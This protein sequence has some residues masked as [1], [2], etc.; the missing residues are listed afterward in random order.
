MKFLSLFSIIIL[1]SVGVSPLLAQT[2]KKPLSFN[3]VRL[4]RSHSTTLS[5]DGQW[6][7]NHY[8]LNDKPKTKKDTSLQQL[9]DQ[10]S[11]D[12]YTDNN[13]TNVLY[14]HHVDDGLK[15]EVPDGN[16]PLF[17]HDSKWIA[18]KVEKTDNDKNDKEKG[19]SYVEL[20][21]LET[22][23]TTKFETNA[24]YSFPEEQDYF[25]SAGKNDLLVFD[26][27]N[28]TE[29]FIGNV[30]EYVADKNSDYVAYTINTE[31]KRGNGIYLYHP[32]D[33]TT[34]TITTGNC[35]FSNLAWNSSA[36]ALASYKYSKEEAGQDSVNIIV[37]DGLNGSNPS[38]TEYAANEI[39]GL[40][41]NRSIAANPG[42]KQN[43]IVWSK[44]GGRL[45]IKLKPIKSD[46]EADKAEDD[47]TVQV[48]HWKDKKLLSER[49]KD[50]EYDM[51]KTYRA[52][53]FR[54]SKKIVPLTSEEL[55]NYIY[56]EG[57]DDWAIGTDNREYLS[58]WDI[59]QHDLYRLNLKTGEKELIETGYR[60][61]YGDQIQVSPD[62]TKAF[63]W[64][65]KDY[66][67]YDFASNT[68]RNITENLPVSF[69]DA[70]YDQWGW[71]KS[72]GFVGWMKDRK[73][74]MANHKYDLWIIPIDGSAKAENLTAATRGSEPIRFRWEDRKS[75]NES[76][77]E[78][79]YLDLS[80]PQFLT[81]FHTKTK[82]SGLYRLANKAV[83]KVAFEPQYYFTGWY[84][85]QVYQ[86]K[87]SDAILFR[88]GDVQHSFETYLSDQDF[89][90][91][92]KIT[93][94][95][96][97]QENYIWGKRIL[98]DY[99]NDDGVPLQGTLTIPENYKEGEKLPMIVYSYEKLSYLRYFY[100]SPRLGSTVPDMLYV[101]NGY[102][103]LEPD[104]HFNVGTPHSDMHESID[105]A[106]EKVIE[107]GYVDEERIGYN[108]F[109]FGG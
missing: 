75:L 27:E 101:S 49:I 88:K 76:E 22:G 17:S 15:Y 89:S 14:I 16:R 71:V 6:Y 11:E 93:N 43:D 38:L 37:I 30:G 29:H 32:Q 68:K 13:K 62:G 94:T 21:H 83:T 51:N 55:Q 64:N 9:T 31:D 36:N 45:F 109:S 90:N 92:R 106:I 66:W 23:F 100:S 86:A 58:D 41:E 39:E 25:I 108:G 3:D 42:K 52:I 95:N 102:L 107:L 80:K 65:E 67:I 103:L 61:W 53:F 28:R 73:A 24:D 50:V 8:R 5:D 34:R 60:S 47:A 44:D 20:K 46:N 63:L 105:A 82:Y 74:V 4:W 2:E 56:S 7:T 59:N 10:T 99:T 104:I 48:W 1:S 97:Q 84:P 72:Y 98:I 85:N 87:N 57:T 96:P 77:W 70:E 81:A 69:I 54:E 40:P 12:F 26:L 91:P 79:R 18:Y 78:K 19:E 33:R 35:I